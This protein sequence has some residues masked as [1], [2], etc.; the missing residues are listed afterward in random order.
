MNLGE[1]TGDAILGYVNLGF[2]LTSLN[3][4]PDSNLKGK[5]CIQTSHEVL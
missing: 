5:I 2:S 3:L 1:S 4:L